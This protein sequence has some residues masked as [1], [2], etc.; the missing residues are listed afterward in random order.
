MG[1]KMPKPGPKPTTPMGYSHMPYDLGSAP[2]HW[3]EK[4]YN[5]IWSKEHEHGGHF[6]FLEHPA[7]SWEALEDFI[8]T[9]WK[10]VS[11]RSAL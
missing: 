10:H 11:Q 8:K 9:A 6:P 7:S 2:I 3:V 4:E 1:P 5:I